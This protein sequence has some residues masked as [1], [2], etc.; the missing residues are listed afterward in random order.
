[1]FRTASCVLALT[2]TLV[3]AGTV[4]AQEENYSTASLAAL[5]HLFSDAYAHAR[6]AELDHARPVIIATG[7]RLVLLKGDERVVGSTVSPHYH[8]LKTIDHVPIAVYCIVRSAVDGELSGEQ[9]EHLAKLRTAIESVHRDLDDI[10]PQPNVLQRQGQ[11]LDRCD[12]YVARAIEQNRCSAEEIDD[13]IDALRPLIMEN[14]QDATKLRID[15]YHTQMLA[16]RPLFR[17]EE[18]QKL[19]VIIPGAAMPRHNSLAVRYFAKV[20]EQD[21]ETGRIIY[22]ESRFEETDA[23]QLLG[24]H[25]IDARIGSAFFDDSTRMTRDLLGP[26]ANAYLDTLDFE[27]FRRQRDERDGEK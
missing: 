20:F 11:I 13:L 23:L 9:Q 16:W 22:A 7:D 15:N 17:E 18:W 5:N 3:Y 12:S 2:A 25:L 4:L 19:K 10:F 24:T 27:P 1:M 21:G 8:D 26:S 14:V 6:A